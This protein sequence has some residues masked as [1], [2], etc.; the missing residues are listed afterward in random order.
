MITHL[1]A[2]WMPDDEL[3]LGSGDDVPIPQVGET[4]SF[5]IDHDSIP[6][7]EVLEFTVTGRRFGYV[8]HRTPNA[9]I[10]WTC[11]VILDGDI[12]GAE[13]QACSS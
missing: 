12:V 11:D 5:G 9:A 4:I 7:E 13:E 8:E 3:L 10:L 2:N 6:F 1:Y